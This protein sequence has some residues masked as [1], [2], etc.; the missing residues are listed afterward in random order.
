MPHVDRRWHIVCRR[1][2]NPGATV[3]FARLAVLI[4]G[5]QLHPDTG[6]PVCSHV[7]FAFVEDLR[8]REEGAVDHYHVHLHIRFIDTIKLVDAHDRTFLGLQ[9]GCPHI[10]FCADPMAEP[11]WRIVPFNATID[12]LRQAKNRLILIRKLP[13]MLNAFDVLCCVE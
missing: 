5:A 9:L 4:I 7:S 12:L 13:L 10:T 3:P 8:V 6:P 11:S 1:C 2:E